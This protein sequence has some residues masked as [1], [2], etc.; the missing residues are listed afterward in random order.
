MINQSQFCLLA[1]SEK[2]REW[3][4][5]SAPE[6][7]AELLEHLKKGFGCKANKE[8]M[9]QLFD[10]LRVDEE[11]FDALQKWIKTTYPA[12]LEINNPQQVLRISGKAKDLHGI[13]P[14]Y[15]PTLHTLP[16]RIII[17]LDDAIRNKMDLNNLVAAFCARQGYCD[18][19]VTADRAY[20]E[21]L[22]PDLMRL[23][24]DIPAENWCIPTFRMKQLASEPT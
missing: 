2:F 14:D 13:F 19:L 1:N 7:H 18:Y 17:S 8:K 5:E 20:V 22:T 24:D 11:K 21:Y 10:R 16:R 6:L 23:V 9:K 12:L 4:K 15:S 3:L